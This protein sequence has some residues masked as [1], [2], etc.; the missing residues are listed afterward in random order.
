M[1]YI[2]THQSIKRRS[3]PFTYL[4]Y[5]PCLRLN[6]SWPTPRHTYRY[7]TL[8]E[9]ALPLKFPI[10]LS[11]PFLV[12]FPGTPPFNL[13][14]MVRQIWTP[15]DGERARSPRFKPSSPFRM[16]DDWLASPQQTGLTVV[17]RATSL[18]LDCPGHDPLPLCIRSVRP[19]ANGTRKEG[20]W[21]KNCLDYYAKRRG[22]RSTD[23]HD[24]ILA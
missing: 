22:G 2:L 14:G 21:I 8:K 15:A 7:T 4:Q 6:D 24:K 23:H 17:P 5:V 13:A 20:G 12:P 16:H 9:E 18:V 10:C 19:G 1:L 11:L 3:L